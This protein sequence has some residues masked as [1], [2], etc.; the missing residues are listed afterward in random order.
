MYYLRGDCRPDNIGEPEIDKDGPAAKHEREEKMRGLI[1]TKLLILENTIW[2]SALFARG[3]GKYTGA[4]MV[5]T[6]AKNVG[7]LDSL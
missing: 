5:L 4:L 7:V 3:E 2:P 6:S 1:W